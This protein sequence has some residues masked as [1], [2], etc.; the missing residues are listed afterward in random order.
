MIVTKGM[1]VIA[2]EAIDFDGELDDVPSYAIDA[3]ISAK[4]IISNRKGRECNLNYDFSEVLDTTI[5]V[6]KQRSQL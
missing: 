4:A 1:R 5:N 3:V 6:L 2:A